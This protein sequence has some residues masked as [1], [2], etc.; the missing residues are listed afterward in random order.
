ML[1]G[2]APSVLLRCASGRFAG[3]VD[4]TPNSSSEGTSKTS[5]LAVAAR[6]CAEGRADLTRPPDPADGPR[7]SADC[8]CGRSGEGASSS[9]MLVRG[10]GRR[11][12][13]P[14]VITFFRFSPVVKVDDM[15]DAI[16][17]AFF[18]VVVIPK[19]V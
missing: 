12:S 15:D 8:L 3:V 19:L 2:G 13:L 6:A 14:Y 7:E 10:G 18:G 16:V 17:H 4:G 5:G 1:A 11:D 9:R